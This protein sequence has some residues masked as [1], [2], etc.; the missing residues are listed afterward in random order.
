MSNI[1]GDFLPSRRQNR[2]RRLFVTNGGT[3]RFLSRATVSR[4]YGSARTELDLAFRANSCL[5]T[6]KFGLTD[7]SVRTWRRLCRNAVTRHESRD[8]NRREFTKH[9]SRASREPRDRATSFYD[10]AWYRDIY[11]IRERVRRKTIIYSQRNP[12]PQTRQ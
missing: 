4:F 11:G 7:S 2:A 12:P 10:L 6:H 5:A 9:R 3:I 8:R 1:P